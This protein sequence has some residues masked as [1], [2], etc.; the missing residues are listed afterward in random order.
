MSASSTSPP[1]GRRRGRDEG[2]WSCWHVPHCRTVEQANWPW[3]Q[4]WY[5]APRAW[6]WTK[7]RLDRCPQGRFRRPLGARVPPRLRPTL[8]HDQGQVDACIKMAS[9]C[10]CKGENQTNK[11]QTNKQRR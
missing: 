5:L 11:T 3:L 4:V 2:D 8:D 6:H 10:V 9:A 1:S 7:V